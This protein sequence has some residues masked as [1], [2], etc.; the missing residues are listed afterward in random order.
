MKKYISFFEIII[1]VSMSFSFSYFIYEATPQENNFFV[2]NKKTNNIYKVIIGFLFNY[3]NLVSAETLAVHTCLETKNG[4]IC[5]EFTSFDKCK[6]VCA[7]SCIPSSR[8]QVSQCTLV[9]CYDGVEGV[10]IPRSPQEECI[11]RGGQVINDQ[12]GNAPQCK[13]GCCI[14]GK[15]SFLSTSQ[16]CNRQASLLGIEKNFRADI[17]DQ[18]VCWALGKVQDE[19]AC[20][21][22]KDFEKTCKLINRGECLQLKGDFHQ[23][24]LC[25]NK[26]LGTNCKPQQTTRCIEGKDEVYWMDSCGNRENIYDVN[27]DKSYNSGKILSKTESCS[28]KSGNDNF[29]N[30][31]RCGNCDYLLG[32]SCS[33]KIKNEKLSDNS[34][35]FVCKDLR[36]KDKNGNIKESGES[37]CVEQGAIGIEKGAG[38]FLRGVDTPGSRYFREYCINGEIKTE[39]CADY[40][41]EICIENR[42]KLPNGKTFSSSACR[43]NPWQIC[44]DLNTKVKNKNNANGITTEDRDNK[45]NEN[46]NCFVKEVSIDKG[47]KFNICAPKY[48]PGFDLKENGEVAEGL[49]N[50]ATQKCTAVYVKKITGWKCVANCKCE[51]ET[52]AQQMNDLCM[53]LGD[54]GASVNYNGDFSESYNV[55]KSPK[56]G[57]GYTDGIKKYSEPI[58]G[59]Y[60]QSGNLSAFYASLGIPEDL[61]KAG[62]P[63]DPTKALGNV[64]MFAGVAGIGLVYAAQAG[65]LPALLTTP[66]FA[67]S[68]CGVAVNPGLSALGGALA[69]AAIGF[70]VV[71]LL[72]KF[73]GIGKGLDPAMVYGLAIAGAVFGA[74]IGANIAVGVPLAPIPVIGL[75][76]IVVMII[77]MKLLGVG[78]T[79]KI[80][81]QFSCNAWQPSN[82]GAKCEQCGKDGF[83]CSRYTCQSLGQTCAYINEGT[84]NELC[85]NIAPNDVSSPTIK[86]LSS[87]ISKEFEYTDITSSGFKIKGKDGE[88]ISSY[89]NLNFGVELSEPGQCRFDVE[90]KNSFDEMEFEFGG[91]TLYSY[92]HTQ[93]FQIP[94][95]ESLGL[96][97]YDP[98]RKTEANLYLRCKDKSGNINEAEFAINFC[99]QPG[100]DLTPPIITDREPENEYVKFGT[101]ALNSSVFTNEPSEC[102]Y[103]KQ[104]KEYSLMEG[105]FFCNNDIEEQEI[106]GWRCS[107][108]LNVSQ[109]KEDE[110]YYIRCKDQPWIDEESDRIVVKNGIDEN[111][112]EEIDYL[113][114]KGK[115]RNENKE[116]YRFIIKKSKSNLNIDYITPSNETLFF[117][118]QPVTINIEAKTSGGV[119]G[120][121]ICSYKNGDNYINFFETFGTI[122]KQPSL[123]FFAG[124]KLLEVRC[125]DEAGNVAEK[126]SR[127]KIEID[128]KAPEV[129]R[130]YFEGQTIK[131]I[132]NEESKCAVKEDSFKIEADPCN[133][134]FDSNSTFMSGEEYEHT[135]DYDGRKLYIKCQDKYGN[136]PGECSI[137]AKRG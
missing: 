125:E 103:S 81:V 115:K 43:I 85:V 71:I 52:F 130:I 60:A 128:V 102:K 110:F 20:V 114:A 16:T 95:L 9:T 107:S 96:P 2:E 112:V 59:K 48:A 36:C 124:E 30:Q 87:F 54:C 19:G 66:G 5:Q 31:G 106:S 33:V 70:A 51:K 46:P 100:E 34:Q 50:L 29:A 1:L 12:N 123:N 97:G 67:C 53:S 7:K 44:F 127:F 39:G 62:S 13:L 47:F 92:N 6:D 26:E 98:S 113:P 14:L 35:D 121:A 122:H 32:S 49:C 15:Q 137:I 73:L 108:V 82:G 55:K 61:G 84:G 22:E 64:G 37:W 38:G 126:A 136:Y 118:Y 45:C 133:F 135:Y 8:S 119:N 72:I 63:K 3:K 10:C 25:S 120:K 94:S 21:F 101:S 80:N 89:Y 65:Y 104:D 74:I 79:K 88:C 99:V 24:L 56:L 27:K 4:S 57:K 41:N 69:G 86:P 78:K 132:T 129:T 117:G 76:V 83:P 18:G 23:G 58:S 131:L 134:Y 90:H 68:A 116:S 109:T 93:L 77:V 91:S 40:R 28:L 42:A 105:Q 75:I 11:K 17:Q 111:G